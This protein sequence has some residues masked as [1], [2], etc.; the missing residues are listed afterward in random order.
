M[1]GSVGLPEG[2]VIAAIVAIVLAIAWPA[3]R[4]CGR[5]GFPRWLGLFAVIPMVNLALLW[6]VALAP[7]RRQP[8]E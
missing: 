2:V 8:R 7:W 4:I 6:F 3:A 5:L 1:F